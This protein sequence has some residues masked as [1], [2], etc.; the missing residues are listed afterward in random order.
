MVI[1]GVD[2]CLSDMKIVLSSSPNCRVGQIGKNSGRIVLRETNKSNF[3]TYLTGG[4]LQIKKNNVI[5]E[6]KCEDY[7]FMVRKS[8]C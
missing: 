5:F 6:R 4:F 3:Y 8:K 1:I 7:D 2:K